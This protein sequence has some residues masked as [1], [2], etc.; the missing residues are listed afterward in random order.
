MNIIHWFEAK[1][2]DRVTN[3]SSRTECIKNI[4]DF[5]AKLYYYCSFSQKKEYYGLGDNIVYLGSI[6]NK[7][8]KP[9]EFRILIILKTLQIILRSDSNVLMCN[10]DL[11]KY[12]KPAIFLNKILGKNNKFV[13]DVRTLPTVPETFE[14]DMI[15]YQCQIKQAFK[16]FDGLSFI[17]PF[18]EKVS[19]SGV[20]GKKPTVNWSSG[21]NINLFNTDKYDYARDTSA[22]RIFYH[23]GISHSRGN[24][25]LIRACEI[26]VQKGYSIE[27]V[28]IGKIVDKDLKTYITDKRIGHWCKLYDAKPLSEMPAMVAHCDLPV[29]PFPNFMAWRVSSPIK[30]MEYL[31]MGKPVLAP[32]MECFTDILNANSGMVHYYDMHNEHVIEEISNAIIH[33]I[34]QRE[35]TNA[36]IKNQ[37]CIDYVKEK[38]TWKAQ[39]HHLYKFCNKLCQ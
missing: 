2:L 1:Q 36:F 38:F 6:K 26:I 14:R 15:K 18:L 33:I 17:T 10:Q 13:L 37:V 29:L 31:A 27:L 11:V 16:L 8:V 30:L 4:L 24:M 9:V 3:Y 22:F 20:S 34:E 7:Y 28:Q 21:V 19:L 12:L 39:V 35:Y 5:G 32:N 23:G 25:N